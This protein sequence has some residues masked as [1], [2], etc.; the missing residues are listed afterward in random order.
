MLSISFWIIVGI[1]IGWHLEQPS[2]GKKVKAKTLSVLKT[3]WVWL[4]KK[5]EDLI[6]VYKH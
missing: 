4:K 1:I 3:F 6:E 5:F 2:W